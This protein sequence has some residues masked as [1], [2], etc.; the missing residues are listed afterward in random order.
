MC[1]ISFSNLIITWFSI[2]LMAW[3]RILPE[4]SNRSFNRLAYKI[5]LCMAFGVTLLMRLLSVRSLPSRIAL[6][7]LSCCIVMAFLA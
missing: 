3:L 7:I 4:S 5:P 1:V 2:K 6:L